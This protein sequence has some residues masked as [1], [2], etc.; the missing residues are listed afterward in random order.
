MNKEYIKKVLRTKEIKI[1][2]KLL[3]AIGND[4]YRDFINDFGNWAYS[5]D[6][7]YSSYKYEKS[8]QVL[9]RAYLRDIIKN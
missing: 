7:T 4:D 6:F 9:L 5:S 3:K 8:F 1:D 2:K